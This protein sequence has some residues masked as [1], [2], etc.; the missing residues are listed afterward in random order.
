[1]ESRPLPSLRDFAYFGVLCT[2]CYVPAASAARI[3]RSSQLISSLA[4]QALQYAM[5]GDTV[6]PSQYKSEP[7]TN[8]RLHSPPAR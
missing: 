4:E 8:Q 3:A 2:F 1:M 5:A 7:G 6:R